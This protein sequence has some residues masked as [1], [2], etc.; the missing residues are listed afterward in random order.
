MSRASNPHH[1]VFLSHS[2]VDKP[3]VE[4]LAGRLLDAGITPWLDKWNLVPGEPWQSEI[5]K[6]LMS[7]NAC[8]VIIGP[9]PLGPWQHEDMR[10]AIA[11]Q[12]TERQ[13]KLRVIPVLL[14]GAGKPDV[15]RLPP[16]WPRT[17]GSSSGLARRSR[18][19][20]SA[21]LRHQGNPAGPQPSPEAELI[22]R[23]AGLPLPSSPQC[24]GVRS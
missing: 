21:S 13:R 7:C 6:A 12:V 11:R 23:G 18:S 2:S 17:P 3:T 15:D 14:P 1:D 20:P 16:S 5:E 8:T 9:N 10:A 19:V 24:V 4:D 22:P